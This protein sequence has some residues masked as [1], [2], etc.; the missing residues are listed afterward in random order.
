MWAN[1]S[2]DNTSIN[3]SFVLGVFADHDQ[4]GQPDEDVMTEVGPLPSDLDDDDDGYSDTHEA[5]CGSDPYD[6]SSVPEDGVEFDGVTCLTAESE[7]DDSSAPFPWW[8]CCL[9]LL[10]LLLLLRK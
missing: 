9:L 8:V 4:D 5:A 6:S 3:T 7:T 2:V 1:N 10:L